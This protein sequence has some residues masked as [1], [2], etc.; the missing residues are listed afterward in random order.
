MGCAAPRLRPHSLITLNRVPILPEPPESFNRR[1]WKILIV[2]CHVLTGNADFV[3]EHCLG[4][5]GILKTWLAQAVSRVISDHRDQL[6]L[7]DLKATKLNSTS[8]RQIL[9]EIIE[10]ENNINGWGQEG[11]KL[12]AMLGLQ[13]VDSANTLPAASLI[14]RLPVGHRKPSRDPVAV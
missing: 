10:G 9:Q 14:T 12:R 5:I 1:H 8:L 4:C 6:T 3:Y 7:V 11:D 2:V 13:S